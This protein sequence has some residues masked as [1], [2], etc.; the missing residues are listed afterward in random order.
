MNI[1]LAIH[2]KTI[3]RWDVIRFLYAAGRIGVGQRSI[4]LF[5]LERKQQ[6]GDDSLKDLLQDISDRG[7]C[8]IETDADN[9]F[10]CKITPQGRDLHDYAITCPNTI[11]RPPKPVLP[12][13]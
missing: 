9:L 11:A 13:A 4:K 6:Y 2:Q 7:Y 5:L 8:T 10:H 12:N 3:D 1:N